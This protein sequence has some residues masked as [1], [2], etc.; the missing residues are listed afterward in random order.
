[1]SWL[2]GLSLVWKLLVAVAFVAAAYGVFWFVFLRAPAA[3]RR[4]TQATV[5]ASAATSGQETA[6]AAAKVVERNTETI[7]TIEHTTEINHDRIEAAAGAGDAVPPDVAAA[8]HDGQCLRALYRG[9][10]SCP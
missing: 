2:K 4:A 8:W 10:P 6:E 5:A 1:V 3:E 7:R 9:G